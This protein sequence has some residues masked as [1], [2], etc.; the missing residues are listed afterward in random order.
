ML[1]KTATSVE[2]DPLVD[3]LKAI[4]ISLVVIG[5]FTEIYI[6]QSVYF[7]AVFVCIY[8]FHIP[9]FVFLSGYLSKSESCKK[10][11]KLVKTLILPYVL[12]GLV[13]NLRES[14]HAGHLELDIFSPPFHLWYL[15]SLFIWRL[16]IPFVRVIKHPIVVSI[17]VSLL[18][19]L[20]PSVGHTFSLSRTFS[21]FPFF[22][23]GIMCPQTMLYSIH[24][25]KF[26]GVLGLA[27]L[28]TIA[29]YTIL[30]NPANMRILFWDESY[31]TSGYMNING[32]IMRLILSAVAVI[33]SLGIVIFT[34]SKNRFYTFIGS[35]TLTI[36]IFHAFLVPSFSSRFPLWNQ[37]ILKNLIILIFPLFVIY[38]FS[39]PIVEKIYSKIIDGVEYLLL[40][41]NQY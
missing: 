27:A 35:R 22:L 40:R 26:I 4:L 6:Q 34:S 20:C 8:S 24:K 14:A 2:R 3:N 16:M 11:Y 37:S 17:L 32:L 19:G 39:L 29:Y 21:L 9:L 13:W 5:H 33:I 7:K 36:Y 25:K 31:H 18:V 38:L 12:F 28:I 23:L 1:K 15:L 30:L 41:K 10:P